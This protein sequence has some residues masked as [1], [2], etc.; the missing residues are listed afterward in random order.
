MYVFSAD[1]KH[2]V[3]SSPQTGGRG[4][5]PARR[6]ET[7]PILFFLLPKARG[8]ITLGEAKMWSYQ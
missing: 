6:G 3:P 8:N 1:D 5:N 2:I 4:A 7:A